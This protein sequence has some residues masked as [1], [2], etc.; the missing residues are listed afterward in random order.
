M[1][2][3]PKRNDT[4]EFDVS[5]G[6]IFREDYIKPVESPYFDPT[7]GVFLLYRRRR[8]SNLWNENSPILGSP[9][10]ISEPID[11]IKSTCLIAM[12]KPKLWR[13]V[14]LDSKHLRHP[15]VHIFQYDEPPE[16][17]S[18]IRRLLIEMCKQFPGA[19]VLVYHIT[20]IRM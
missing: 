4:V 6:L 2:H 17:L 3:A 8:F 10:S 5:Q 11:W 9:L 13:Y 15:R 18:S 12:R 7:F 20:W 14:E 1:R 19:Q 16:R